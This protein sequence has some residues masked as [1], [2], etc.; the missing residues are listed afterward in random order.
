MT[1]QNR[2]KLES[3]IAMRINEV[4]GLSDTP[5]TIDH[6][7]RKTTMKQQPT[8]RTTTTTTSTATPL[9]QS[10]DPSCLLRELER[11]EHNQSFAP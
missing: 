10:E 5:S 7:T 3:T 6:R 8:L 2:E 4:M 9:P 1:S 11:E